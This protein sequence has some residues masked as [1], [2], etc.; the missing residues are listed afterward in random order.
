LA[1]VLILSDVQKLDL[2]IR[3]LQQELAEFAFK[4]ENAVF[5]IGH[6]SES[7]SNPQ[8]WIE[9]RILRDVSRSRHSDVSIGLPQECFTHDCWAQV[10]SFCRRSHLTMVKAQFPGLARFSPEDV[11]T[12]AHS[13]QTVNQTSAVP[14]S[15]PP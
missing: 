8:Q 14:Q 11:K 12:S 5:V 4:A 2:Q 7:M 3:C 13:G 10:S 1:G 15:D 6:R 9:R